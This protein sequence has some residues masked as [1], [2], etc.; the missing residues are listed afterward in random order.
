MIILGIDYGTSKVGL[1]LGDTETK[2]ATPLE[3][4]KSEDLPAYIE[5]LI[6]TQEVELAVMGLP[7]GLKGQETDSTRIVKKFTEKL[8]EKTCLPM[9]FEDERYSTTQAKRNILPLGLRKHGGRGH[10]DAVAAMYILQSYIDR[11]YGRNSS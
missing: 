6:E 10:D 4:I 3:T 5:R 8:E 7:V 1:S 2:V 9:V 11:N